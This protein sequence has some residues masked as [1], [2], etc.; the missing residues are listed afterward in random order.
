LFYKF[1]TII[2]KKK[3]P[4]RRRILGATLSA[5]IRDYVEKDYEYV[6]V[7]TDTNLRIV[8]WWQA[9]TEEEVRDKLLAMLEMAKAHELGEPPYKGFVI[10]IIQTG[11]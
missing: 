8:D 11:L 2:T 1:H 9:R 3:K 6:V 4:V 10:R 7:V 5:I